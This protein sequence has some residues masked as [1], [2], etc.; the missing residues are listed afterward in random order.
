MTN[1]NMVFGPQQTTPAAIDGSADHASILHI[2]CL[3]HDNNEK[4]TKSATSN[5]S[6]GCVSILHIGGHLE[7]ISDTGV[8]LTI[9]VH[10]YENIC[11]G[12]KEGPAQP[13]TYTDTLTITHIVQRGRSDIVLVGTPMAAT[14]NA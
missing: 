12:V 4:Q 7:A 5:S 6:A 3:A 8:A 9:K 13:I 1:S 14:P 11:E 10:K 2:G